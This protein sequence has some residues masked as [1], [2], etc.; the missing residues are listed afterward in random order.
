MSE[1]KD[2]VL[3]DGGVAD[4]DYNDGVVM[5]DPTDVEMGSDE[6]GEDDEL[7]IDC[8]YDDVQEI[9]NE[10]SED[11]EGEEEGEGEG[12]DPLSLVSVGLDEEDDD[13]DMEDEEV[14]IEDDQEQKCSFCSKSFSNRKQMNRHIKS[15]HQ[16]AC[17][18]ACQ[19]CGRVLSDSDSYR[20]H[21]NN[22]HQIKI[23]DLGENSSPTKLFQVKNVSP[24]FSI[25]SLVKKCPDCDQQFATK[26]TLN[27]H[28]LKVHVAGLKNMPCPQC[29]QECND[30]TSHMRRFHNVDGIVCPHCANIFSKK[31][32]LNRHIEQVHLNIQIH[33]PATCPECNKVFSKKGH[34][35]RHIKIIHQGIKDYSDP[36]PYCGKVF[37]TRASL[38]PHIAMVHEGVRKKC[39]ICNKVLSDLNKHMRT[40][41]GT[42]RRKAK[43]P[44]ELIGEMDN[45]DANI[46]PQIYG[47]NPGGKNQIAEVKL[48]NNVEKT[49]ILETTLKSEII[50]KVNSNIPNPAL[51]IENIVSVTPKVE[52]K[53]DVVTES[54][55]EELGLS[56]GITLQKIVRPVKGPPK[57]TYHGPK[58][59]LAPKQNQFGSI[60]IT[61]KSN[62]LMQNDYSE[63]ISDAN[64]CLLPRLV[65]MPDETESS[66]MVKIT[67]KFSR[68][69]P[70]LVPL[71]KIVQKT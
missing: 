52:L 38:E 19:Y 61:P 56:S 4:D 23:P 11:G 13:D 10:H 63:P 25:P 20:R 26:T 71:K 29:N 66:K 15:V 43:I 36:C 30:L 40:V 53:N 70:D 64:N 7:M 58:N 1:L 9:S 46:T 6:D 24:V 32:T 42:Y 57:L 35:D 55:K 67:G 60:T 22:V 14:S 17:S 34:L 3:E 18:V 2:A 54:I 68:K 51:K 39:S 49:S 28:R 69:L 12:Y 27:I 8:E 48:S 47:A 21:L 41:H 33:K 5:V 16:K 50:P 59:G 37:T 31:C 45:P 62:F 44:K 65:K